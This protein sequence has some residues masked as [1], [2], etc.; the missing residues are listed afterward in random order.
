MINHSLFSRRFSKT[1]FWSAFILLFLLVVASSWGI[2]ANLFDGFVLVGGLLGLAALVYII[3]AN[4][5]VFLIVVLLPLRDWSLLAIG[6][7]N[8]RIG[9]LAVLATLIWWVGRSFVS[10][11]AK[12]RFSREPLIYTSV[13]L[14]VLILLSVS[15]SYSFAWGITRGLKIARAFVVYFLLTDFLI[16]DWESSSKQLVVAMLVGLVA[17][18]L[19]WGWEASQAGGLATLQELQDFGSGDIP[20][21]FRNTGRGLL[22]TFGARTVALYVFLL[23]G[24]LPLIRQRWIRYLVSG[25]LVAG[26]LVVVG[27]LYRSI[28]LGVA[29][30][31][32]VLA[33]W[34]FLA[35]SCVLRKWGRILIAMGLILGLFV[36]GLGISH[37]LRERFGL[38]FD[39]MDRSVTL[40][41]DFSEQILSWWMATP[42]TILVG[43]GA[44]SY[45]ARTGKYVHN[46]YTQILGEQGVIGFV[47]FGAM[48]M[49]AFKHFID[50]Y[51]LAR[52]HQSGTYMWLSV[53]LIG[54]FVCYLVVSVA[55][56][57]FSEFDFWLI[58]A[59]GTALCSK[60]SREGVFGTLGMSRSFLLPLK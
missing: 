5:W 34:S 1:T 29:A 25:S 48:L 53:T 14:I 46:L 23:L 11:R 18:S 28:I 32:C 26:A 12:W 13:M 33:V 42:R 52:R 2:A 37:V 50:A 3:K 21:A 58:A 57:D 54:A 40:R 59:I 17:L 45:Q 4:Q 44:G 19:A 31:M 6:P 38:A 24:F 43:I 7:A 35:P 51:A 30:G 8:I 56:S 55:G 36:S 47:I 16:N 39:L 20:K 27:S 49:L 22:A 10:Q 15:W 41:L 9:D 60:I